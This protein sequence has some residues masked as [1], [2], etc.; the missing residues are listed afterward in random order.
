MFQVKKSE[1][2]LS[3]IINRVIAAND[4]LRLSFYTDK[5]G[6]VWQQ[7]NDFQKSEVTFLTFEQINELESFTENLVNIPT[8]IFDEPIKIFSFHLHNCSGVIFRVH[9]LLCDGFSVKVSIDKLKSEFRLAPEE[10]KIYSYQEHIQEEML[11]KESKRFGKN[12]TFWNRE[13]SR[14]FENHIFGKPVCGGD[15]SSSECRFSFSQDS[16]RAA[17]RLCGAAEIP[18]SAFVYAVVGIYVKKNLGI[19]DF[20]LGMPIINRHREDDMHTLGLYMHEL[21]L[22]LHM[23]DEASFRSVLENT[24][25]SITDLLKN[26][27][28]TLDDIQNYC[29]FEK[30]GD[31]LFDIVIDYQPEYDISGCEYKII[32]S[33]FLSVP[34]E[35]HFYEKKDGALSVRIRYR[36]GMFLQRDIDEMFRD[37]EGI[38]DAFVKDPD[39]LI[40]ETSTRK[41]YV[42]SAEEERKLLYDFNDTAAKYPKEGSVYSLFEE[43][44]AGRE[45]DIC[46][47][48]A[49]KTI[50]F[51]EFRE[52]AEALDAAIRKQTGGKKSVIAVIADRSVEMYIAIYAILR[53][54]SAYMPIAPDYPA[55]RISFMLA[56]SGAP[57]VLAQSGYKGLAGGVPCIDISAFDYNL[58][59]KE[60]PLCAAAPED[61]AYVIYTSGSTGKPK[62]AM[63]SHRSAINRILWMQSAYP[64]DKNSVIL[65]KTP[66][67]FDVSVWELF[68][69]GICRGRLAAMRPGEHFL[70]AAI[71]ADCKK[72]SVTHLH[73]V[74]SVFELFLA[75]LEANPAKTADFG[76][77]KYVFL[78]GEALKAELV[79]RFYELFP[80]TEAGLHNLYGPTECAVDVTYYDCKREETDPV[81]IGKPIFNTQAYITDSYGKLVP[82]GVKGEL[83][84][85]GANVGKGYLNRPEL[86]AEKFIDNPFGTGKL[87]KTGDLAYWREDGELIFCG[88]KD[89]QIKLN[90]QRIELGE[91]EAV[92]SG[93]EKLNAAAAVICRY[94]EKDIIAVYYAGEEIGSGEL[95]S[96]CRER[97]PAYMI[98]SVFIRLDSLPLNASGK[99]DRKNLA[100]R[101]IISMGD[102][103]KTEAPVNE[104]EKWICNTFN[105]VLGTRETDRNADFYELGGTSLDLIR[106]L[107]DPRFSGITAAEFVS[108]STPA[109]LAELIRSKK[110]S[111]FSVLQCLSEAENAKKALIL[112]PFAGG[113]AAAF[114]ALTKEIKKR[115]ASVSVY[116]VDYP[117]KTEDCEKAADEIAALSESFDVYFYAH[118]VGTAAALQ[119][120]R[121]LESKNKPVVKG[122]I[123]G[124]FIPPEKP[125]RFNIWRAVPDRVLTAILKK[126]GSG[127]NELPKGARQKLLADFRKNTDF[128]VDYYKS[129]RYYLSIPVYSVISKKDL[130]TPNW[131]AAENNWRLYTNAPV[132]VEYIDSDSH[133]FQSDKAEETAELINDFLESK[134]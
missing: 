53:G 104:T 96:F 16:L 74:P 56:D 109:K 8:S 88:R 31:N 99:L 40:A 108:R 82:P 24:Y 9:H 32:Y 90:G 42:L 45:N 36:T 120:A 103:R 84:I 98:P 41:S 114:A 130:F 65:Q 1:Q 77:V 26:Q 47:E 107:S 13:L 112:F 83:C 93:Y 29:A 43:S 68:W 80:E 59:D 50:T 64:L 58:R 10:T 19:G 4:V 111:S 76:S 117:S 44:V 3:D 106:L 27:K 67:T 23:D 122:I 92:L 7:F 48:T 110:L 126:A 34:L 123:S 62:G 131:K 54:G 61:T 30:K 63:I 97:L 21:P 51:A 119:T 5:N 115:N 33:H 22:I 124:G 11:Y 87:Y 35:I 2:E 118:C 134:E 15:Y 69:W 14:S 116:Y 25:D 17:A 89:F 100:C 60:L 49:E 38:I 28:F 81:P 78:S 113:S 121:L 37:F 125:A 127:I 55:D 128:S 73:F 70:P 132:I 91:I 12:I 20:S 66:Y 57:L 46:I 133:Y 86:T 102:A 71:L 6:N 94:K 72:Y 75:Y 95:K 52:A 129:E 18:F 39:A 101:E 85:G 79:N 105:E